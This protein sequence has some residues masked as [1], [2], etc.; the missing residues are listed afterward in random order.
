MLPLVTCDINLGVELVLFSLMVVVE[1]GTRVWV[2][3][4]RLLLEI[5]MQSQ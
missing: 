2:I 4:Q 5:N 1:V 3:V